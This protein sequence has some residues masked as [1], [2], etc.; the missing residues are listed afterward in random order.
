MIPRSKTNS[1]RRTV[2]DCRGLP[3]I[4]TFAAMAASIPVGASVKIVHLKA[5]QNVRRT[6]Q[7]RALQLH[8]SYAVLELRLTCPPPS[9]TCHSELAFPSCLLTA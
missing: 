1:R 4:G 7:L 5:M 9:P 3:E 2:E 6:P 8:R